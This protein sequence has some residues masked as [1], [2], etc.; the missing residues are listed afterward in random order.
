MLI[1]GETVT[2]KPKRLVAPMKPYRAWQIVQPDGERYGLPVAT[3]GEAIMEHLGP[4][5][6]DARRRGWRCVR[7][8][9][10]P[11]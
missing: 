8:L 5:W 2:A 11:C 7:V 3:R 6:R 1:R 10:T 4:D 9:V